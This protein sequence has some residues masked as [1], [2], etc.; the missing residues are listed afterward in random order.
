MINNGYFSLPLN[1]LPFYYA[2][3]CSS[4]LFMLPKPQRRLV[5][6]GISIHSPKLFHI[7]KSIHSSNERKLISIWI[8]V[9]NFVLFSHKFKIK[10]PYVIF[11]FLFLSVLVIWFFTKTNWSNEFQSTKYG[12]FKLDKYNDFFFLILNLITFSSI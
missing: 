5:G 6:N 1:L 3:Y 8:K 12:A 9:I 4:S 11:Q 2:A 7:Y 10:F